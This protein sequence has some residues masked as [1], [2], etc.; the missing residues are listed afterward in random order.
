MIQNGLESV[1]SNVAVQNKEYEYNDVFKATLD[2]YDG[3]LL[4]TSTITKKYLLRNEKGKYIEKTPDD[5]HNRLASEF[6]RIEKK[7]NPSLNEA[8][9][10]RKVRNLLH[11]F[12]K[13]SAQGS[14]MSAIGNPYQL[15]SAS[16][17]FHPDTLV[18]TTDGYKPIKDIDIGDKVLTH[19]KRWR[20]VVNKLVSQY[21]GDLVGLT[22]RWGT[23]IL[24]TPNHKFWSQSK[25]QEE[26]GKEEFSWNE[27]QYLRTGDYIAIASAEDPEEDFIFDL[28]T[29]SGIKVDGDWIKRDANDT[30]SPIKRFVKFSKLARFLGLWLGDGCV[31]TKNK[32]DDVLDGIS[33]TFG[34]EETAI[35]QYVVSAGKEIF[36]VEPSIFKEHTDKRGRSWV[37]IRFDSRTLGSFFNSICGRGYAGKRIPKEAFSKIGHDHLNQ[38]LIGLIESD[39]LVTE[40]G[41]MRITMA[42]YG[43]VRDIFAVCRILNYPVG[44][45]E[46]YRKTNWGECEI[47]YV[48]FGTGSPLVKYIQKHY[49][50]SRIRDNSDPRTAVFQKNIGNQLGISLKSKHMIPYSG[51]VINLSVE[52]DQSYNVFGLVCK[53]CFVVSSPTDSIAGVFKTGY[54]I[55]EIQKRRGGTGCDLSNLR[56]IGV[57]VNNAAVTSTGTPTFSDFY[58]HITRM[59][60]QGGRSGA[61]MLTLSIKHPD[62][63]AFAK[64]KHDMTK[65]T[66]ANV[67][68]MI[69]DEFM[70]ALEKDTVFTQQWPVDVPLSEAKMTKEI[71]A[72]DLWDVI[73]DSAWRTAEPGLLMID[74]YCNNLPADFYPGYKSTSTNPCQPGYA[75]L[76][77]P[78]GIRTFD[79]VEIGSVIWSGKQWT[80]ITNKVMTGI[81]S[82]Y[83]Y[84][85]SMGEFIGTENHRILSNGERIEVADAETIDIALGTCQLNEK[86]NIQDVMDGLVVGDGTVHKASN[87]LMLLNLGEGDEEYLNSEI[88][89]LLLKERDKIMTGGLYYEIKTTI[90]PNELPRT[91]ERI[92]PERFF[93]GS[94]AT[95]RGFLRGLFSANGSVA[96]NGRVRLKQS[97]FELVSQVQLM[98]S[99]IGINSYI[100]THKPREIQFKNGLY[101]PKVSY[102]LNILSDRFKFVELIGFIHHRKN[103]SISGKLSGISKTTSNIKNVEFL[104]ETNVYDITVEAEEHTYWTGGCLVSNCSEILLSPYDSCR[105]ISNNLF[106]WVKEPFTKNARFDFDEYYEDTKLA[107]RISDGLVELELEI[108]QKVINKATEESEKELWQKIYNAG[109]YG[110]RTGLGTHALA[111]MFLSLGLKYDTDEAIQ[112]ADKVYLTHKN[113]SYDSSIEMAMERGPFPIWDWKYD[114]KCLFI[115]RLDKD[116]QEMIKKHG[117][118]NISNLTGAPTGSVSIASQTSSGIEP[119]FRW[120]YDRFMKITYSDAAFP[121]DRTDSMGDKWTKFRVLHPAVK[122]YFDMNNIKCPVND[123]RDFTQSLET[124]NEILQKSLPECFVT[125]DQID[126]MKGV[127][128]QGVITNH[129]DHGISKTINLPKGTTKEQ[130]NEVYIKAHALGI[131]GVTV[132]VDG[133]RDGVLVT[134]SEKKEE[135][136]VSLRPEKITDSHAPKRPEALPAEIHH[137]KVKG[138]DW[139]VVVGLMLG[140]PFEVFAG[141]GLVLP[142]SKEIEYSEIKR[143]G[144]KKYTLSIKIKD[145]GI[146]EIADIRE[147]Y[148]TPEQRTITR[149]VCRDLRHGIPLE[150]IVRDLQD[151]EGGFM[152]DY[153]LVLARVLKK[154]AKKPELIAKVCPECGGKEFEMRDGCI[155]C[156]ACGTGKCQ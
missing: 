139:A 105:L 119:V 117:R 127:E 24:C 28:S 118:R 104:E 48:S 100:V 142:K 153:V 94:E 97:S 11:R 145:N 6:A 35:H 52:E 87:N 1:S 89:H 37:Q 69:T 101:T 10:F 120:V 5:L 132:Y 29:L 143:N 147:I 149:G 93:T 86:I 95:K 128:L 125:S 102:D 65:V 50:D 53:N 131:K 137:V 99:S 116:R 26:W 43:L 44:Y 8:E 112:F 36:G 114:E 51:E 156:C 38:L 22:S 57:R 16:N 130:V 154:Y 15:Q 90:I 18:L 30:G 58:S 91:Y 88:S 103:D 144:P 61:Q 140:K 13:I 23:K 122:T 150:F 67:S 25:E 141:Q 107:Q 98:L 80:T 20:K 70:E 7:M 113:A 64:M 31:F 34:V 124:A 4:A 82:V 96:K 55:A 2:Y 129:T 121:V 27:S 72:R 115:Q 135:K 109:F 9:Y 110:R 47:A 42:N 106:G 73:V 75:T 151:Y 123:G 134:T 148:D 79:D 76:L 60:G 84:R 85:T 71:R 152:T 12:K 146:E 81:K 136:K 108:V 56:P 17:C 39:G 74:N 68:L 63:Q 32:E 66:G 77:T 3:D 33:F 46:S 62:A 45:S 54:E 111:D 49:N 138:Q 133:S 78:K 19:K 126:Y 40:A 155:Y 14:P 92:V 59:I 41:Q 83:K 21:S